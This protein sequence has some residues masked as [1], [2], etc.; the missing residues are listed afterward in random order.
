VVPETA[1]AAA[2]RASSRPLSFQER[3]HIWFG[4][5]IFLGMTLADWLAL[6][7]ENQFGV[8]RHYWFRAASISFNSLANSAFRQIEDAAL[9]PMV[10]NISVPAP[11]FIL[12]HGCSGTTY[13][14]NLLAMDQRFS[15]P[16]VYEV[17]YPHTFLCTELLFSRL[18]AF[19]LPKK[20]PQNNVALAIDMPAED[21]VAMCIATC[22]SPFMRY[23][24]PEKAEYYDRYYTFRTVSE[25]EKK[26][27]EG[28]FSLFLKKLTWKY[29][30]RPLVLKSPPHTARIRLL[31]EMFPNARF[32]HIHRNPYKVFQST[33]HLDPMTFRAFTLQQ[34]ERDVDQRI[35]RIYKQMYEAFF[36]DR[37]LVPHGQF[38]EI[39]FE[40]LEADPVGQL[41]EM[42]RAL[43]LPSFEA[44]QPQ[45]QNYVASLG[46]YR[47]NEFPTVT[48][49]LRQR[50]YRKWHRCFEEWGYPA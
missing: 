48:P 20:R 22:R 11:L 5:G 24:F 39:R 23:V 18:L 40:D 27:W 8:E 6:L 21:E 26:H 14:Y 37:P 38:H 50:I 28:A 9:L 16:N 47:K 12:G 41:R 33:K 3:L 4:P 49:R 45:L 15:Y 1:T 19:F 43:D 30:G 13:L 44:F 25:A 34:P 17:Y 10:Q 46:E 2:D 42:Y 36:A 35:L 7:H 31:L 29:G 32:V